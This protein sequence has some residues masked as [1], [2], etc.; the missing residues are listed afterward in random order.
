[1]GPEAGAAA[2]ACFFGTDA[3]ELLDARPRV[4][5]LDALIAAADDAAANCA[6]VTD[7]PGQSSSWLP[8]VSWAMPRVFEAGA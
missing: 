8:D 6:D 2:L 4:E 7:G 3:R 5:E 1:M